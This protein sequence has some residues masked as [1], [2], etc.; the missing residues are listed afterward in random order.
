MSAQKALEIVDLGG[1]V[2]EYSLVNVPV[3]YVRAILVFK[4]NTAIF[5]YPHVIFAGFAAKNIITLRFHWAIC[6]IRF[7]SAARCL[8]ANLPNAGRWQFHREHTFPLS[9]LSFHGC[10]SV[11]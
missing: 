10:R 9:P 4:G 5:T 6:V 11:M 1:H 3:K 8:R 2:W 7:L